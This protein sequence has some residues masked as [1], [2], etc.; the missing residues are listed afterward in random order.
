MKKRLIIIGIIIFIAVA[1][2]AIIFFSTNSKDKQSESTTA[3]INKSQLNVSVDDTLKI[4]EIDEYYGRLAVVVENV[5]GKD[6][7]YAQ[8]SVNTR[9][10]VLTFK[11]S[12]L[13]KG[14]KAVLLCNEEVGMD[15]NEIYSLWQTKDIIYFEKSPAIDNEKL[16]INITK[17][18]ISVKNISGTDIDGDI[19]IYYKDKKDALVNGSV[20]YKIRISGL[21]SDSETFIKTPDIDETNCQIIFT[22]YDEK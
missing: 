3:P 11:I 2:F 5:S 19:I 20:T 1:I 22:E 8:L 12:A 18:S 14:T 7:E 15:T 16:D 21:K 4:I 6:I 9:S 17:G 13:L 10:K